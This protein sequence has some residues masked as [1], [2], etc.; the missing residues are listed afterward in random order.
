M[1]NCQMKGTGKGLNQFGD[2]THDSY[3]DSGVWPDEVRSLSSIL[4]VA[5]D[6]KQNAVPR[7]S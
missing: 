6:A 2:D 4:I 3:W 1:I 5:S 7:F